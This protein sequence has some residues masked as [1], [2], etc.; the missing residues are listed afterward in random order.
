MR[1]RGSRQ[2]HITVSRFVFWNAGTETIRSD[3]FTDDQLRI[4]CNQEIAVLDQRLVNANDDT[5]KITIGTATSTG[6]G[7]TS[8][9]VHFDYLDS[10]DGGVV[11]IVHDGNERTNFRLAGTLKG[12]CSIARSESPA[13]RQARVFNQI[14]FFGPLA[15]TSWFGWLGGLT[16][17]GIAIASLLAPFLG[18]SWWFLALAAFGFLAGWVIIYVYATGQVPGHFQ[19][20]LG[21]LPTT[22]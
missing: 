19:R 2:E 8:I 12:N 11:Q 4:T 3:D 21:N 7:G 18:A 15:K 13:Y 6:E 10:N 5:N 9:K 14:P 17:L 20:E 1:Y 16:Y 22:N